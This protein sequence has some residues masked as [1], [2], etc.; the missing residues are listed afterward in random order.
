M[1]DFIFLKV[2]SILA[3]LLSSISTRYGY[4]YGYRYRYNRLVYRDEHYQSQNILA[5]IS[6]FQT[7]YEY[8]NDPTVHGINTLCK[9]SPL[10]IDF[11]SN[12]DA[13][14][15]VKGE[16]R[17]R[18]RYERPG[19]SHDVLFYNE[20]IGGLNLTT[21]FHFYNSKLWII[22]QVI[23]YTN[24][25][26]RSKVIDLLF[27]K[28]SLTGETNRFLEKSFRVTDS[29]GSTFLIKIDIRI[30]IIYSNFDAVLLDKLQII[31]TRLKQ[32]AKKDERI[33]ELRLLRNL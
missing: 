29:L 18:K 7:V 10:D 27:E 6:D 4:G 21:Q 28:Y 8:V 26:D 5:R 20:K 19:F 17:Y 11:F 9:I 2:N 22:K 25:K 33:T 1:T 30:E 14:R 31:R 16:P 15:K 32:E 23:S 13:V 24:E 12:E 3:W